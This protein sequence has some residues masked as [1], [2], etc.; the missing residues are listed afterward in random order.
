M[1]ERAA[2]AAR[3]MGV[4]VD[5]GRC[6]GCRGCQVACKNW[7]QLEAEETTFFA[8]PGYQNPA[9]LSDRTFTFVQYFELAG[10]TKARGPAPTPTDARDRRIAELERENTK[11]EKRARRAEA[12]VELQKKVAQLLETIATGESGEK[13]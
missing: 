9:G 7:N 3:R 4:L 6:T 11:L 12:M 8:G 10:K 1:A 13:P 2:A 5:L